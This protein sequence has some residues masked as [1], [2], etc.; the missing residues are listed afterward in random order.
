MKFISIVLLKIF[1]VRAALK[2]T[3]AKAKLAVTGKATLGDV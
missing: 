3:M 2:K 1:S